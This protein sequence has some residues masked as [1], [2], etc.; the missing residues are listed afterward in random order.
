MDTGKYKKKSRLVHDGTALE[1]IRHTDHDGLTVTCLTL[2]VAAPGLSVSGVSQ[3][4]T[5]RCAPALAAASLVASD[6]ADG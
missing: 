1:P 4:S 6:G 3:A 2:A 5:C